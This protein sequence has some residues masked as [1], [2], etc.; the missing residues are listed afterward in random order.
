MILLSYVFPSLP[1]PSITVTAA[2][3]FLSMGSRIFFFFFLPSPLC[4]GRGVS[5]E[6]LLEK[7]LG[8]FFE[9]TWAACKHANEEVRQ[10]G[11]KKKK[12]FARVAPAVDIYQA[13][14][15]LKAPAD[16]VLISGNKPSADMS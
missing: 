3:G 13:N 7:P 16:R 9:S 4:Y 10:P 8:L 11:R 12:S 5:D 14:V 15:G 6:F 1:S 2:K